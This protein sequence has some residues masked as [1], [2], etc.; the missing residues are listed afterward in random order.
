MLS[1]NRGIQA[2]V[3]KLHSYI[4]D[5]SLCYFAIC[6][7]KF[8]QNIVFTF[9]ADLKNLFREKLKAEY[10]TQ[11][12]DYRSKIETIDRKHHFIKYGE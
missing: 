2:P 9:L 4:I 1:Q 8:Q 5:D 6:D 3:I 12:V 10:G 11:S 7:D